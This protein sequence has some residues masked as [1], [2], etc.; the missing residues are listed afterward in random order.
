MS[1]LPAFRF[2]TRGPS[3]LLLTLVS[4]SC[5]PGD[6]RSDRS[7]VA[8]GPDGDLLRRVLVVQDQR[9]LEPGALN[10][11]ARRVLER[12]LRSSNPRVRQLTVRAVGRFESPALLP[13]LTPAVFDHAPRVRADAANA[14]AQLFQWGGEPE[15]AAELLKSAW[16][17][18]TS[19]RVRAALARS[20]G[21]LPYTEEAGLRATESLLVSSTAQGVRDPRAVVGVARGITDLGLSRRRLGLE[22]PSS[23]LGRLGDVAFN[24][25]P[26]VLEVNP[27]APTQ[28]DRVRRAAMNGLGRL[29]GV[30][31][32]VVDFAGRDPDPEVRRLGARGAGAL[33]AFDA[34]RLLTPYFRD[35]DPAV[36]FEALGAYG[37]AAQ[38][39]RGCGPVLGALSDDG[40]HT[41]LL[42]LDLLGRGCQLSE[43]ARVL[44]ALRRRARP[45]AEGA[46]P[47]EAWHE[48]AH[49]LAA[50]A[51]V[52]PTEA[53]PLAGSAARGEPWQ[54]RAYAAQTATV[55]EDEGVLRLLAADRDPNVATAAIQGLAGLVGHEADLLYRSALASPDPQL[56]MTA[57]GVLEGTP[58]GA[59]ALFDLLA[60]LDRLTA[61]QEET[62][63]DARMAILDRLEELGGGD[64]AA[65]LEALLMD[66]D[67]AVAHR[68]AEI[69]SGWLG[70][71]VEA[72]PRP[73]ER[74]PVPS[75]GV[76]ARFSTAQVVFTMEGGGEVVLSLL[77]YM[78]PT[79]VARLV[80][81]A[82][83]GELDGLT[84]H[85]IA[86]N[87]VVQGL[88]PGANEFWGHGDFSRDEVGLASNARTTVG[89]STRGRD[90][91][92][93][94]IYFNT[95]DNNRLDYTYT[96]LARVVEGMEVVDRMLEGAT[97]QRA[98]VR[99]GDDLAQGG[100]P[101]GR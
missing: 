89:L 26:G 28:E 101:G 42:A 1:Y 43:R 98:M 3:A 96:V 84:L 70:E 69:L 71:D 68:S 29:G 80:R 12:G 91:G 95:V 77:P 87:F 75:Q 5:A 83:A 6:D 72:H 48:P 58:R 9:G 79:N 64:Q 37:R 76:L 56:V 32:T 18:E 51:R 35:P 46:W 4:L 66:Y 11:E 62:S 31:A 90:T 36:R 2:R 8:A 54:V 59:E 82:E 44:D 86:P 74:R 39:T 21:R 30:T 45:L 55:L 92:D 24:D 85:R 65:G 67:P 73:L 40:P 81:L 10:V 88:S 60:A 34:A 38:A 47:L 93:G 19:P 50:L 13:L 15:G 97:V 61:R 14:V 94:Q 27:Y 100:A 49:A 7:S 33:P 41:R 17:Q 78:A 57:A 25:E 63:R 22:M 99:Y 52:A 23:L 53:G 16:R 20:L